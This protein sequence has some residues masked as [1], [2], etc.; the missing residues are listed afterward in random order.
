MYMDGSIGIRNIH[1]VKQER[2]KI[3]PTNETTSSLLSLRQFHVRVVCSPH[4]QSLDFDFLK[5][6]QAYEKHSHIFPCRNTKATAMLRSLQPLPSNIKSQ[7]PQPEKITVLIR[8]VI[9]NRQ[10]FFTDFF[11]P[12]LFIKMMCASCIFRC[13]EYELFEAMRSSKGTQNAI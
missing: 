8:M 6:P 12:S 2:F 10:F 4:E 13:I 7:K 3:S 1:F 9:R 5:L 11:K